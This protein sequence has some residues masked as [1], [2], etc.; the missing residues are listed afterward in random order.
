[1]KKIIMGITFVVMG[2]VYANHAMAEERFIGK[3][4][5]LGVDSEH[6]Y[7]ELI[8]TD[9][10]DWNGVPTVTAYASYAIPIEDNPAFPYMFATLKYAKTRNQSVM[11]ISEGIWTRDDGV[12]FGKIDYVE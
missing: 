3:M 7:L 2:F 1:M 9:V 12:V 4:S 5:R 11:I 10:A 6:R 8:F